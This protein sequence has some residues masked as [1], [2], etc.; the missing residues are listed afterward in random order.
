MSEHKEQQRISD[1]KGKTKRRRGRPSA[2]EAASR[3]DTRS[4]LEKAAISIFAEHGYEAVSTNDLAE[5]ANLTQPMV[6]YHFGT[7]KKLW[8]AAMTRLM[9]DL[10]NRFPMDVSELKDLGPVDRLKV[11]TRR[12]ILMS[13]VDPTLSKIIMNE[14]LTHSDRLTWLV[15]RYIRRGFME[16]DKAVQAGID[17][18][19]IR[20]MPVYVISNIIVTASSFVFC[21]NALV[22]EVY[23]VDVTDEERIE[24]LSDGIVEILFRGIVT[25]DRPA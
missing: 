20:D 14:G 1:A 5:A 23:D 11:I 12:F 9:R 10:G 24:E 6:H 15:D 3:E 2:A 17:D 25:S 8:Q 21:C 16:F 19:L 7:K 18:G 13:S 4:R 22:K